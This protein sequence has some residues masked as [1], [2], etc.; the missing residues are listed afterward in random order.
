MRG[1]T[2]TP[3]HRNPETSDQ[4]A[5]PYKTQPDSHRNMDWPVSSTNV[6]RGVPGRACCHRERDFGRSTPLVPCY[7]LAV[8]LQDT[9]SHPPPC[10]GFSHGASL[11]EPRPLFPMSGHLRRGP[12]RGTAPP[13]PGSLRQ[14]LTGTAPISSAT[15]CVCQHL[16]ENSASRLALHQPMARYSGHQPL[17]PMA[18]LLLQYLHADH[19]APCPGLYN[20]TAPPW[21]RKLIP[22]RSTPPC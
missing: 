5:V 20:A 13:C 3:T 19:P 14:R 6:V 7:R 17:S 16:H 18:Y 9:A 21:P 8:N 15:P 10:T 12:G 4:S 11:A 2:I 22:V 1:R